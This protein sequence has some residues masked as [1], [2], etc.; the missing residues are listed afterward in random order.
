[1]GIFDDVRE[2]WQEVFNITLWV[3]GYDKAVLRI[4]KAK[5][6]MAGVNISSTCGVAGQADKANFQ[7]VKAAIIAVTKTLAKNLLM[8]KSLLIV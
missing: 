4:M 6:F 8:I 3:G 2:K 7:Q 1:M 5:H